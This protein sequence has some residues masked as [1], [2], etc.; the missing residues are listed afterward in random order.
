MSGMPR[1][2]SLVERPMSRLSK[3][4]T[5]KPFATSISQN[6]SGHSTICTPRPITRTMVGRPASPSDSYSSSS[7]ST[8]IFATVRIAVDPLAPAFAVETLPAALGLAQAVRHRE[9]RGRMH[10]D[11]E[12]ARLEL[13]ALGVALFRLQA[14]LPRDDPVGAAEDGRRGHGWGLAHARDRDVV[15]EP[16]AAHHL[17]KAPCIVRLRMPGEGAPERDHAAHVLR[18][19]LGDLACEDASQAPSDQAHL[20]PARAPQPAHVLDA[21]L[22]NAL[23]R[24]E[25]EAQVPAVRIVA[26]VGEERA[27][28]QRREVRCAEAGKD[29]DG[30]AVAAR[31]PAQH[32]PRGERR[33]QLPRRTPL[34]R[35]Q[36]RSGGPQP[37]RAAAHPASIAFMSSRCAASM[38][39]AK[40]RTPGSADFAA[41]MPKSSEPS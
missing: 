13:D 16:V 21:S 25:V 4:T 22:Q 35:E 31:D 6:A 15:V 17:V 2:S 11:A 32:R 12:M 14:A 24:S 30:M 41:T 40:P 18:H 20:A 29:H 8:A 37:L 33:A 3:R 26:A 7:P 5:R 10:A 1:W 27:Q 28:R 23:A 39:R 36:E 38:W 19:A 34:E 9:P